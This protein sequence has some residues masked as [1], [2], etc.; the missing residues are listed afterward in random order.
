MLISASA[1]AKRLNDPTTVILH[2]GSDKDYT[3]GHIPGARLVTL[4][5]ISITGDRG[6]RLELPPVESLVAAFGKLG[7]TDKSQVVVYHGTE[8]IQSATRVWFTLDY[9]GLGHRASLLDGGLAAWRNEG[10]S[11]TTESAPPVQPVSFA[12]KPNPALVVDA[13]WIQSHAKDASVDLVDARTPEFYS[14][15][16]LGSMPRAGRIPGA[17]SVPYSTLLDATGKLKAAA[18][19]KKA[20]PAGKLAVTYCHI[21]QQ[22][23][24]PYFVAKYLGNDARL[25][26]GS[27]QDWSMRSELPVEVN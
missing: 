16:S 13:A 12:V 18:E 20:L 24:L 9:L 3:A 23:T 10:R 19:L 15:A 22:A 4:A 6:L 14:G 5:D 8:S 7:V 27:F 2:V 17:R 21:G 1:L 11:L 26:D 25:Y